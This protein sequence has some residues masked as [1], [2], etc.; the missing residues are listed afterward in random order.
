MTYNA[1]LGLVMFV[2]YL[3]VYAG[4]VG[5]SAFKYEWMGRIVF[6]GLNLAIVY[7]MALIILAMVLAVI[8]MAMCRTDEEA[9]S[10]AA[11]I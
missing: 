6:A 3:L 4:F 11:E 7:G 5:I 1:R 2:V 10:E 9:P 8:Y